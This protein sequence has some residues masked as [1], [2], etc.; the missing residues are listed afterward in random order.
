MLVVF[1]MKI[2]SGLLVG[3]LFLFIFYKFYPEKFLSLINYFQKA[4]SGI[5]KPELRLLL[6]SGFTL[7]R[8]NLWFVLLVYIL[9]LP[10]YIFSS[11]YSYKTF[12]RIKEEL[13]RRYQQEELKNTV[14][15]GVE[16]FKILITEKIIP[17]LYIAL[18][19]LDG[20]LS[21]VSS[22][23]ITYLLIP[24]AFF[25]IFSLNT[26]KVRYKYP[27]IDKHHLKITFLNLLFIIS[28]IYFLRLFK[29]FEID[30]FLNFSVSLISSFFFFLLS[31]P[32]FYYLL[33]YL[34]LVKIINKSVP[35]QSFWNGLFS[36]YLPV[37]FYFFVFSILNSLPGNLSIFLKFHMPGYLKMFLYFIEI[38]LKF[39]L[40]MLPLVVIIKNEGL[41]TSLKNIILWHQKYPQKFGSLIFCFWGIFILLG[42]FFDG[43][44][45]L[46]PK[47]PIKYWKLIYHQPIT[48]LFYIFFST[49]AVI[50]LI[51]LIL[52]IAEKENSQLKFKEIGE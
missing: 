44:F 6:K 22:L 15:S 19:S 8:R 2:V 28:G 11:I 14:L 20:A 13:E 25:L 12:F 31:T 35:Q 51:L 27:F 30:S 3:G 34:I 18:A 10:N 5:P 42:L 29:G 7:L 24:V 38:I 17:D 4:F 52:E 43:I 49:W 32:I 37:F 41:K 16:K 47:T 36:S 9:F 40:L 21:G 1:L 46:V 33:T 45:R 23:F 48:D 50:C 39:I 26:R